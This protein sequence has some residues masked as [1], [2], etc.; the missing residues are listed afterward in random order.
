MGLEA[1]VRES[2]SVGVREVQEVWAWA[3]KGHGRK[4]HA[5]MIVIFQS[6]VHVYA[7]RCKRQPGRYRLVMTKLQVIRTPSMPLAGYGVNMCAC[8]VHDQPGF[9]SGFAMLLQH[10]PHTRAVQVC[11]RKFGR[12][13]PAKAPNR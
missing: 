1:P 9:D 11:G 8:A 3:W 6:A 12:P 7:L 10:L 2:D 4:C 13:R 5:P